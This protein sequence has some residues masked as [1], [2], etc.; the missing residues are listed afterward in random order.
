MDVRNCEFGPDVEKSKTRFKRTRTWQQLVKLW[1]LFYSDRMCI[2]TYLS[3][4]TG[5]NET[6]ISKYLPDVDESLQA[7]AALA[8][9]SKQTGL[10]FENGQP[11]SKEPLQR[12]YL[13]G[14]GPMSLLP[15][16]QNLAAF[17]NRTSGFVMTWWEENYA[18]DAGHYQEDW[19]A[20]QNRI[21]DLFVTYDG[22]RG[23]TRMPNES[24]AIGHLLYP[25][26]SWLSPKFREELRAEVFFGFFI[27]DAV[28]GANRMEQLL[29]DFLKD[30]GYKK[31]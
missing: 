18:G 5:R 10:L 6:G 7:G 24:D 15:T 23:F 12:A 11:G 9:F 25:E 16:V 26:G 3:T 4:W 22:A 31:R 1:I 30:F 27:V 2:P 19:P 21:R 28:Y 14:F 17:T 13:M 8:H 29:N 20:R